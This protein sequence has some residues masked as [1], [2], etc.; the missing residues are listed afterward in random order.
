MGIYSNAKLDSLQTV[1]GYLYTNSDAKLEASKNI[2]YNAPTA[3]GI[4]LRFN[5][6]CFLKLGFLFA[7]GILA[8]ILNRR[9][10]VYKIQIVGKQ[11]ISY[12]VEVDG[13]FSHGATIKEAKESLIYKISNRDT[14]RYQ[15]YTLETIVTF[16]EAVKMYRCIT[17][18]CEYGTK[19]F[20]TTRLKDKKDKYTVKE[21]IKLTKGQYG[22][23]T[24]KEFFEENGKCQ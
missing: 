16:E 15:D 19:H 6:N 9:K 4:A 10:N 5:F 23:E 11:D 12:C 21:V 22:N 24:F 8:K 17:G 3:K 14:S 7:D 13:V 18:A 2:W 20:C 1:G